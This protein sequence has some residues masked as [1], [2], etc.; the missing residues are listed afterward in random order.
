MEET[1]ELFKLLVAFF[2]GLATI[3]G[4]IKAVEAVKKR[5]TDKKEVKEKNLVERIAKCV[6]E[7]QKAEFAEIRNELKIVSKQQGTLQSEKIN[8]AYEYFCIK[9]KPLPLY[10]KNA[11]E[12]MYQQY[13]GNGEG[14]ANSNGV[15]HDFLEK[16]SECELT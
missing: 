6:S 7:S 8:W 4:G 9:R 5:I 1:T 12:K 11:L 13:T 10:Q 15:P 3:I 2:G 14:E 16:L